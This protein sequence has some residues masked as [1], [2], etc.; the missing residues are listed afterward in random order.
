MTKL[1]FDFGMC[2]VCLRSV[3]PC[4]RESRTSHSTSKCARI[5]DDALRVEHIAQEGVLASEYNMAGRLLLHGRSESQELGKT[6]VGLDHGHL[7]AVPLHF[8]R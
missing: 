3:H 2:C 5:D 1:R 4:W 7:S 6:V 8:S